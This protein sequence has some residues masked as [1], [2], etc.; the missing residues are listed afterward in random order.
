MVVTRGG[1]YTRRG[2]RA[3]CWAVVTHVNVLD[4][5]EGF[6]IAVVDF[7]KGRVAEGGACERRLEKVGEKVREGWGEGWGPRGAQ[8][9]RGPGGVC[10]SMRGVEG[11]AQTEKRP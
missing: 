8:S 5:A 2:E 9:W 11:I 7:V 1:G 6:V 4:C 10:F 3:L